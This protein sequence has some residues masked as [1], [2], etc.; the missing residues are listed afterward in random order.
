MR[1]W[2]SVSSDAAGAEINCYLKWCEENRA[3]LSRKKNR[4]HLSRFTRSIDP[5]L[6]IGELKRLHIQKWLDAFYTLKST[7]YNTLQ[8]Q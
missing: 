6:N 8:S 3:P 1:T 4:L 5:E 2:F 7:T